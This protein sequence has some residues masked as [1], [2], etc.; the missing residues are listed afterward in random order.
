LDSGAGGFSATTG[1]GAG[2][3]STTT[4]SGA[5]GLSTT[6]GSGAGGLST[7]TGSGEAT[8]G[9]FTE[10]DARLLGTGFWIVLRYIGYY[11]YYP[12]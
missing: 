2:G 5:G 6:T 1:S 12:Y 3:L 11:V 8:S 9:A 7:T 4:G 10:R